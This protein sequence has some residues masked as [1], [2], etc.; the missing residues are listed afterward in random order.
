MANIQFKSAVLN[1][2][3]PKD[4]HFF[5]L[6][7]Q[8]LFSACFW[9]SCWNKEIADK[10]GIK[11]SESGALVL[12]QGN[13]F[14]KNSEIESIEKQIWQKID[15]HDETFFKNMIKVAD[16]YFKISVAFGNKIKD[17]K[18]IVDDLE[19]YLTLG[20]KI[21]FLW[22]LGAEQ[23][24]E[25]AQKKLNEVAVSESFPIDKLSEIIPKFDTPLNQQHREV[26]E[27]K[28]EIGNRSLLEIR[29]DATLYGKLKDHAKRFSWIEIANL[30]GEPLTVE[31]LYEQIIHSKNESTTKGKKNIPISSK[32]A[33]HALCFSYCGYIRQAAAEY[34]FMLSANVQPYLKSIGGKFGL[35]YQEFLLQSHE[36]IIGALNG[37][38][39]SVKLKAN[40]KRRVPMDFVVFAGRGEE[41]FFTEEPEDIEILK[42]TMIPQANK[43][44]KEIKGQVGHK[45]KYT[46]TARIIMNTH[47]F[48]KMQTGDV[49]VSTM[50]TPDFVV[51]MHKAGAIVT[52]IGGMLCHAAIVSREINK[53]CVIGTKFATQIIKDGDI[54]EVDADSGTV[55]ILNKVKSKEEDEQVDLSKIYSREKTLFY[56]SMWNDSDRRGWKN[57]LG[58]DVKNNLFIVPAQGSKGS[59]WYSSKELADIDHRL[60]KQLKENPKLIDSFTKTLDSNWK[61]LIPYIT[62]K[63]RLQSAKEFKEYYEN[64]VD[65]WSAMNTAFTLPDIK[66]LD[67]K[68]REHFLEYRAESE[69]YT[70]KM[71]KVL[72]SFWEEHFPNSREL[73][74]FVS[75]SEVSKLECL[76]IKDIFERIKSRKDGC[77]MLNEAIYPINELEK[78]LK[79]N[80]LILEE[81]KIES[82]EE[83]KGTT[84]YKGRV[85]GVVRMILSFKDMN[86]F[87]Q[88]EI[89]VTEMTNPDY[90]PIMKKAGAIVTDEGGATCHA[91]IASRELGI[92]CIVGTKIATKV[93]KD[94]DEVDVDATKGV[95][96]MIKRK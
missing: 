15:E 9:A 6:W 58:Y 30:V 39:N 56:F 71:N 90:L 46:G 1:D 17:K 31:R 32:L 52:D 47:D 78:R 8:N 86:S 34:F 45:G 69:K 48:P 91:A 26:T 93:L 96:K 35:T 50:T 83:I 28:K 53:P 37:K 21:T 51:L 18:L 84:A 13:F 95:I 4:Y 87:K 67:Q 80:R 24:S 38:L 76:D 64:L 54:V 75:P 61:K 10:L 44:D 74:F 40:A 19:E 11:S 7:K 20:R 41:V 63:K 14:I 57:F 62:D 55:R 88:G 73:T 33:F 70:E 27:L 29:K 42:Q 72:V 43:V 16:D 65:W 49:L 60:K 12:T 92:P 89:L 3:N 85:M 79:E 77:I 94:G 66:E 5:G 36:E 81:T 2:F 23:F 22:M 68:I 25:A 82:I 59:V